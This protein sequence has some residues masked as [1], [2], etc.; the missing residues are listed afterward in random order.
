LLAKHY[1]TTHFI[2]YEISLK[3]TCTQPISDLKV[4]TPILRSSSMLPLLEIGS[5]S[6]DKR[7]SQTEAAIYERKAIRQNTM[8]PV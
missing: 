4:L 7:L 5:S 2:T 6:R 8:H 3:E 1:S